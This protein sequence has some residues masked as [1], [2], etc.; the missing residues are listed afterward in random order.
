LEALLLSRTL[1]ARDNGAADRYPLLAWREAPH[2]QRIN[3]TS[4]ASKFHFRRVRWLSA[5][6]LGNKKGT[7]E[8]MAIAVRVG[9]LEFPTKKAAKVFFKEM[10]ARYSDGEDT[11]AEDSAHLDKLIERHPEA[12]QKIGPGIKR[13]YRQRTDKGTSCFWLERTDGTETEFSYPTCVDAKEKSLYEEFAEACREAVQPDL[14]ATKREYFGKHADH[15]GRVPCDITGEMIKFDESHLDHKKPMTFQVIV[16]T[17]IAANSI[18]PSRAMLSKPRDQ[19]FSTTFTDQELAKRFRDYHHSLAQLRVIKS[20][21]NLS[22]GGSERI[23]K[24]KT[25]ITI[26]RTEEA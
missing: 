21:L 9:E 25:P 5:A 26:V 6:P 15:E 18:V 11:N 4:P 10:L 2:N 22:L 23:I 20:R 12:A 13:F 16:R 7:C 19:Q 1:R 3:R 17:F 24:S 14:I 8:S